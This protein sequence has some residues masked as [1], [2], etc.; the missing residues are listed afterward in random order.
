MTRKFYHPIIRV[1]EEIEGGA[2]FGTDYDLSD[3]CPDCGVGAIPKGAR[4]L[5]NI[6]ASTKPLVHTYEGEIIVN[7]AIVKALQSIGVA[8]LIDIHNTQGKVQPFKELRQEAIL[9]PF[10]AK[11]T[12]YETECPC[13]TCTLRRFE[14]GR[15]RGE[16][17][18]PDARQTTS[19]T[20]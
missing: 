14:F 9:P 5:K 3:A 18:A 19:S 8:S 20:P 1:L 11:T 16:K 12:G 17:F 7:N 6:P 4:I 15:R 2:E 13:Q 10:S